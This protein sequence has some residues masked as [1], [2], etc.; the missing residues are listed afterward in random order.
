MSDGFDFKLEGFDELDKALAKLDNR[1]QKRISLKALRAGAKI[2]AKQA[3]DNVPVNTGNLR[4]SIGTFAAKRKA[5]F[6]EVLIGTRSGKKRKNDGFYGRFV[7]LGT[8]KKRPQP[9]LRPAVKDKSGEAIKKL[10]EVLADEIVKEYR[11]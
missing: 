9:F 10:G 6:K 4:K 5:F 1:V 3:K 2:I 7:E 8:S 11:K